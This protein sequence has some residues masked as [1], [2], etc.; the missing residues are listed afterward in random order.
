MKTF[1]LSKR[2]LAYIGPMDSVLTGLNVGIQVYV[3][4]NIYKRLG[5]D[6]QTRA[7][8]DLEKGE[9]YVEE[10]KD[11]ASEGKEAKKTANVPTRAEVDAEE[12]KEEVITP[13]AED[14][15]DNTGKGTPVKE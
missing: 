9:L 1:T 13:S 6:P 12:K 14:V 8:Y 4:N 11:T 3:V 7:R 2:D 5:I 15:I 10:E